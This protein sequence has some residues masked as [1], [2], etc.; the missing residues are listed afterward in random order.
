MVHVTKKDDCLTFEIQ[1][2]HKLW[3]FE[4]Q[5]TVRQDQITKAYQDETAIKF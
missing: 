5:I 3:A 4:N 1:G 2:Q